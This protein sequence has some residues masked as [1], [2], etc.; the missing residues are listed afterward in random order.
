MGLGVGVGVGSYSSSD[1]AFDGTSVDL[2]VGSKLGLQ[3]VCRVSLAVVPLVASV[4][5]R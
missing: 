2:S 1:G 4:V 3:L 5:V